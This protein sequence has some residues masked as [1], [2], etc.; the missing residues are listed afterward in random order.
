MAHPVKNVELALDS[1]MVAG[2]AGA[3]LATRP[4][5]CRKCSSKLFSIS[6]NWLSLPISLPETDNAHQV[7]ALG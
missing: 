3:R 5:A 6:V 7:L 2:A 4:A 1:G